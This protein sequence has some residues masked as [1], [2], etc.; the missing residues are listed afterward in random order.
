ML[1]SS[2]VL[3]LLLVL[4]KIVWIA[5]ICVSYSWNPVFIGSIVNA[6]TNFLPVFIAE[7]VMLLNAVIA[8]V[9]NA[10]NFTLT[11]SA[12]LDMW[13]KST[14]LADWEILLNPSVNLSNFSLS[15]NLSRVDMVVLVPDSNCLLSN[16]IWT[17]LCSISVLIYL[18][19]PS[20]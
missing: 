13:D 3:P 4:A 12:P 11:A 20:K 2:K 16:F 19:P 8:I 10:E 17:T 15:F 9:C 6:D 1:T 5:P 18:W 14:F 7:L